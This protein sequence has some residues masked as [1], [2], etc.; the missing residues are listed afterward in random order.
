MKAD[1]RPRHPLGRRKLKPT[2]RRTSR[3]G[4]YPEVHEARWGLHSARIERR[5]LGLFQGQERHF[6]AAFIDGQRV[7]E[8][9]T[10]VET[11]RDLRDKL[12]ALVNED[13]N[14]KFAEGDSK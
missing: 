8:R 11:K 7:R 5:G 1:G 13:T 2:F 3:F 10:L 9:G 4:M 14:R 6:I 12:V